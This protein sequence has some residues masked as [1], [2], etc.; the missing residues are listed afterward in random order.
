[1]KTNQA[2]SQVDHGGQVQQLVEGIAD[3]AC[4]GL[5]EAYGVALERVPPLSA[6]DHDVLYSGVIGFSGPRM[7]GMCVLAA[8]ETPIRRSNPIEGPLNDWVAELSN[9]LA[10]RMK[11]KLLSYGADVYLTTPVVLR[12]EHLAPI[13]NRQQL[14]LA[15]ALPGGGVFLWIEFDL[16]DGMSLSPGSGTAAASEGDALLFF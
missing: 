6:P 12:G 11:N 13:P 8:T 16:D 10:G 3:E 4:I 1:M 5:F 2:R 7:R 15:Y 9:Q 14:P